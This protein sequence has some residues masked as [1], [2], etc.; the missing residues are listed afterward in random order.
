MTSGAV[1]S[2]SSLGFGFA[3]PAMHREQSLPCLFRHFNDEHERDIKI[4]T[5]FKR[6]IPNP[7]FYIIC[8][9]NE[10]KF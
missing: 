10:G 9:M 2:I 4:Y 6:D 5:L 1:I 7:T 3:N 8:I